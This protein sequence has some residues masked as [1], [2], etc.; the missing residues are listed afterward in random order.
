[1][2]P[3]QREEFVQILTTMILEYLKQDRIRRGTP[4]NHSPAH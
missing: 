2:T 1:M 4:P 3:E